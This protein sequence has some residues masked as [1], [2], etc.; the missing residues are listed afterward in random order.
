ME[1]IPCKQRWLLSASYHPLLLSHSLCT[2]L[3]HSLLT[4]RGNFCSC[5]IPIYYQACLLTGRGNF[6]SCVIPIYYQ[7]WGYVLNFHSLVSLK[8]LP[9]AFD[10]QYSCSIQCTC[11]SKSHAK[12]NFL[13]VTIKLFYQTLVVFHAFYQVVQTTSPILAIFFSVSS[14]WYKLPQSLTLFSL[15]FFAPCGASNIIFTAYLPKVPFFQRKFL[16]QS[17]FLPLILCITTIQYTLC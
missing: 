1:K 9:Y 4:G 13:Q 6:C 12:Y 7:A 15:R 14:F 5:V 11:F 17:S 2:L 8:E 16:V 10:H 3:L